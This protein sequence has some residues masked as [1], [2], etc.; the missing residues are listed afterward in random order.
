[1]V[2]FKVFFITYNFNFLLLVRISD[3]E[4]FEQATLNGNLKNIEWL[5]KNG[6]PETRHDNNNDDDDEDD[7]YV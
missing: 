4:T 7:E 6:C 1:M 3:N 2:K 5:K